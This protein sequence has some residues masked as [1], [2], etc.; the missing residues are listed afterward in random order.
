MKKCN[1]IRGLADG[2]LID[3]CDWK[4]VQGRYDKTFKFYIENFDSAML[5][6]IDKP[7]EPSEFKHCPLCGEKLC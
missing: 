7:I 4:K 2:K 1:H 5:Y 6:G 3:D